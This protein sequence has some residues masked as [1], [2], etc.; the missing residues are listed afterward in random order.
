MSRSHWNFV[1][2][3]TNGRLPIKACLMDKDG[4]EKSVQ[5]FCG[6]PLID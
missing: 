4:I 1:Y 5:V 6:M 3:N 2:I